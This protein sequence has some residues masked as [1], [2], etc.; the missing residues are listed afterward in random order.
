[1]KLF[2][3]SLICF[4]SMLFLMM[5]SLIRRRI[6]KKANP[7]RFRKSYIWSIMLFISVY[8][9]ILF[10]ESQNQNTAINS[11]LGKLDTGMES[12]L[13]SFQA[14]TLNIQYSDLIAEIKQ[15]LTPESSQFLIVYVYILL[16]CAPITGGFVLF[17]ILV[18]IFPRFR[19]SLSK[20][21]I[22]NYKTII[23]FSELNE[24]SIAFSKS[25]LENKIPSKNAIWAFIK[26]SFNKPILVFTDAYSDKTREEE[27]EIFLT[28]RSLGAICLKDDILHI[29]LRKRGEKQIFLIDS[30]EENNLQTLAK[31]TDGQY[32]KKLKNTEIFLFSEQDVSFFTEQTVEDRLMNLIKVKYKRKIDKKREKIAVEERKKAKNK[33]ISEAKI[34]KNINRN[35]TY[36]INQTFMPDIHLFSGKK[37]ILMNLL[38]DKPLFEPLIRESKSGE[39][40][41]TLVGAGGLGTEAFLNV[42][43]M[44]QILN[45]K[46]SINVISKE[47]EKSFKTKINFIN[48]EILKT[49]EKDNDLLRIYEGREGFAEPYF[50]FNYTKTDVT[51]DDEGIGTGILGEA[52]KKSD[53]D[54]ILLKSDYIIV[55]LGS[56]DENII[57][58]ERIKRLIKNAVINGKVKSGDVIIAY[59]VYSSDLCDCLNEQ[60]L[61]GN[62]YMYA[63]GSIKKIYSPQN[64]YMESI[65]NRIDD[66]HNTYA[67]RTREV[68]AESREKLKKKDRS[69][70]EY[71]SSIA[72]ALHIE[73]KVFS[74]GMIS[75]SVF[76]GKSDEQLRRSRE[77]D[78]NEY[79]SKINCTGKEA[80]KEIEDLRNELAWLEH[81]RWNAFMRVGGFTAPLDFKVYMDEAG[82][83]KYIKLKLHPCIVE[84]SKNGIIDDLLDRDNTNGLDLL[85]KASVEIKNSGINKPDDVNYKIYD[86]PEYDF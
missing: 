8:L 71:R 28:A 33:P 2:Y 76:D 77:N 20:L 37:N 18:G 50:S 85:D 41:V 23:Y 5:F 25:I 13:L 29:R 32:F 68:I 78:L 38:L 64:V 17:E 43:W 55:T 84:C 21:F 27:N 4:I 1:M 3:A 52:D 58:A 70:Y 53:I 6:S 26:T 81:R 36:Y 79:K 9:I 7:T 39:L 62:I 73:Y 30:E 34:Q 63:F 60:S 59:A 57:I 12:L 54:E 47:E 14:F 48:P 22:L 19:Y 42:Y 35:V 66:I 45:R 49:S 75:E 24:K 31:L 69:E 15:T 65:K 11:L 86:Y 83:Y 10:A 51:D 56:D 61:D 82:S 72:R 40:N 16:V 80:T 74:A 46:L 44:G 67:R